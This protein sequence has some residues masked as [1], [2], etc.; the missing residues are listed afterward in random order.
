MIVFNKKGFSLLE[1]IVS[2]GIFSVIVLSSIAIFQRV[3]EGQRLAIASQNTQESLRYV[4][5]VISKEI[6][7]AKKDLGTCANVPDDQVFA[8]SRGSTLYFKNQDGDCVTY[9]LTNN[10]FYITR[11]VDSGYITPD[12]VY[13]SNLIFTARSSSATTQPA[14]T[15]TMTLYNETFGTKDLYKSAMDLQT[16]ISSRSYE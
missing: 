9:Q 1:L 8:V 12:E 5:E 4:F 11:G 2:M 14:V 3:I 15:I 10:R 6:R 7:T 16:T 13:I